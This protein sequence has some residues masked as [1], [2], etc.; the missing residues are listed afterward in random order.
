MPPRL[1]TNTHNGEQSEGAYHQSAP[2]PPSQVINSQR[3]FS[4]THDSQIN[5]YTNC[6]LFHL[7]FPRYDFKSPH[8]ILVLPNPLF[9]PSRSP[10]DCST[11]V[12]FGSDRLSCMV[13]KIPSATCAH[14]KD[15]YFPH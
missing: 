6:W 7:N 4:I 12:C 10:I 1:V 3:G 11:F 13:T 5:A 9:L 15:R 8:R 14:H 2:R